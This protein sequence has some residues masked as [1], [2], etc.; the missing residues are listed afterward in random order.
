MQSLDLNPA[1]KKAA[2]HL[3]EPGEY[4]FIVFKDGPG[5]IVLK[6]MYFQGR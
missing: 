2:V 5:K 4:M 6:E 1:E 3:D